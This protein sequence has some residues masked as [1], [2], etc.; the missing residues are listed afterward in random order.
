MSLLGDFFS[1]VVF[2]AGL[3]SITKS[4]SLSESI[5]IERGLRVAV[6]VVWPSWPLLLREEG[7]AYI[8]QSGYTTD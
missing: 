6:A 2:T 7:G 5:T 3:L 1:F 4:S 8:D